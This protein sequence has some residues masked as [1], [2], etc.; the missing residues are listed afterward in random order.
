[1]RTTRYRRFIAGLLAA[2]MLGTALPSLALAGMVGT[3]T[4]AASARDR[5]ATALQRA[6]VSARLEALGVRPDDVQARIAALSD[7]EVAK[8]AGQLDALPAG[9]DGIIGA[10]VLVFLVLLLTDIVGLTK[11][12]PFTR[13][14][15]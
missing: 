5:V 4:V 14:I 3:D 1:M 11:I 2:S 8:L 13:S 15:K 10:I 6:D 7:Q 12:F 9:G